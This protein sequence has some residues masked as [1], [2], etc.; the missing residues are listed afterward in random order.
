MVSVGLMLF[1]FTTTIS[2]SYYGERCVL[3]L[4]GRKLV[5]PYRLFFVVFVFIGAVW[6]K[7]LVWKFVD[8]VITIMTVPNLIGLIIL[9]PLVLKLTREYFAIE[10]KRTR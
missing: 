6:G 2:W 1:A 10:H 5:L 3:Y 7:E 8:A 4:F 9:A